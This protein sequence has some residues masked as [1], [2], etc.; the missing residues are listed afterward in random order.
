MKLFKT[1]IKLVSLI[2]VSNFY[3]SVALS[4]EI[5]LGKKNAPVTFI[6][7]GSITCDTCIGFHRKIFP[8]VQRRYIDTG[9]VRFIYRHFPTSEAA[10]RGAVATQ[11]AGEK[12]YEMLEELYATVPAW[13]QA[14]DRDSQF[15]QQAASFGLDSSQFLVCLTDKKNSDAIVTQQKAARK[16]LDVTGTPTFVINGKF[17]RGEQSFDD[18]KALIDEALSKDR[19]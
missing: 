13:Y 2:A 5:A 1:W 12:F 9:K 17:I 19:R 18:I 10:L 7:Y 4:E 6:E 3:V 8:R 16:D 11:C 15:V 14:E